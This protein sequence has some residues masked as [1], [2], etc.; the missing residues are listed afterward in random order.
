MNRDP[1]ELSV[2]EL[3]LPDVDSRPDLEAE[4]V[5]GAA[6]RCGALHRTRRAVERAQE[7]V[8]RRIDLLA[9]EA[10]DLAPHDI[11]VAQQA[12]PPRLVADL[13]EQVRGAHDVREEDRR[14]DPVDD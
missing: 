4:L 8:A 5:H 1:A 14:E 2:E 6:D 13:R 12:I 10:L 9:A 7:A 11:V 3:A